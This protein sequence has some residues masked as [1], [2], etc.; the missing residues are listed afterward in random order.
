M[1]RLRI[2]GVVTIFPPYAIIAFCILYTIAAGLLI[3]ILTPVVLV[4]LLLSLPNFQSHLQVIV[5]PG[6]A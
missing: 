4:F 2:S 3:F 5:G 1:P 6:V